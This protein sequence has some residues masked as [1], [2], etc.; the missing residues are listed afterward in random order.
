MAERGHPRARQIIGCGHRLVVAMLARAP[1]ALLFDQRRHCVRPGAGTAGTSNDK[2]RA[3]VHFRDVS[4]GTVGFFLLFIGAG[5]ARGRARAPRAR[6]IIRCGRRLVVAMLARAPPALLF[7]QR[8]RCARPG[9][10]TAGTSNNGA[11]ASLRFRDLSAGAA[12]IVIYRR[13][14]RQWR[15]AGTSGTSN[16][17]V[18]EPPRRRDASAGTPDSVF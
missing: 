8:R 3:S 1:P 2:A 13:G 6:Q 12:G 14:H 10:G 4:A 7:H 16:H 18:R 9:A 5:A 17:G 11:R 15:S